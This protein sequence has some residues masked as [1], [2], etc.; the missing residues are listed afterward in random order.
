MI[1]APRQ[2]RLLSLLRQHGPLSRWELHERTGLRPNTV[3]TL[4]AEMVH[5]GLIREGDGHTQGPGR[6]RVPLEIDPA[7]RSVLGLALRRDEVELAALNLRGEPLG[8]VARQRLDKPQR[9]TAVARSLYLAA[10][11]PHPLLLGISVPGLVDPQ[12]HRILFSATTSPGKHT[13]ALDPIYRAVDNTP[14]LLDND[15]H[16]LA[17]NW[18]LT[19]QTNPRED[20]LL[21]HVRDGELGSALLV[22][23]KPNHGCVVG[24]NE[25]GHTRFLV[26]TERCFCG[27]RGCLERIVSSNF[28]HLQG[29][30]ATATLAEAVRHF[31]NHAAPALQQMLRY[32]ATALANGVNFIRPNRL[33]LSGPLM[34]DTPF[35]ALLVE[36]IRALLLPGIA[37][38]VLIDAWDE[39]PAGYGQAAAWLALASLYLPHWSSPITPAA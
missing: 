16:A 15:M 20:V 13:A 1:L 26:D 17:A 35:T 5:T 28:L 21:V 4:V 2:S 18:V 24:A 14:I 22:D 6:P 10:R 3:G 32:L 29:M 37:D 23:G 34:R 7:Q 31:P 30:P 11:F 27:Q 8:A 12:T 36:S 39:S 19:E 38:R 9:V 33:V 25:L